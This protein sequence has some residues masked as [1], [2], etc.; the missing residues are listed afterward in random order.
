[1][2][3]VVGWH[4]LNFATSANPR[5][6]REILL[7]N[8]YMET[9]IH[10]YIT[11]LEQNL[12]KEASKLKLQHIPP[13]FYKYRNLNEN[14]FNCLKLSTIWIS[15]APNLNDPFESSLFF[16][17]KK[18]SYK[19]LFKLVFL[20]NFV[21]ISIAKFHKMK[22]MLYLMTLNLN[23]TFNKFVR[24]KTSTVILVLQKQTEKN[25][26]EHTS[27]KLNGK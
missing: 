21:L 6:L 10:E 20:N 19:F 22:L 13:F 7:N 3:V 16:D 26:L 8:L 18:L 14:T 27:G 9:W 11:L 24:T 5:T 1:L 2:S 23:Y 4:F 25:Y 12:E 15:P 17:D